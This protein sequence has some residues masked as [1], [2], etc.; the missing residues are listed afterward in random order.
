M[1]LRNFFNRQN[2]RSLDD[3]R[4]RRPHK[5]ESVVISSKRR[6]RSR[7]PD[8]RKSI[9]HTYELRKVT[10]PPNFKLVGIEKYDGKT[11]RRE[12]LQVYE[13]TIEATGGDT[14]V[15]TNYLPIN[16]LS[17]A[18]TWLMGLPLGSIKSWS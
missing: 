5:P 12:W 10:W 8:K 4:A 6:S 14:Q 1:D 16:L 18:R 7:S 13:L 17:A 2:E 11:D 15:M 3:A 9:T